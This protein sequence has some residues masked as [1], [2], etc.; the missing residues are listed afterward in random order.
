MSHAYRPQQRA[1]RLAKFTRALRSDSD[2]TV[3][4]LS[5]RFGV[6]TDVARTWRKRALAEIEKETT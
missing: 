6:S 2:L 5:A 4:Q 3:L 1:A